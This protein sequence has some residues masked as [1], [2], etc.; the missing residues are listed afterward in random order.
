MAEKGLAL[1][2]SLG[3]SGILH[4]NSSNLHACLLNSPWPVWGQINDYENT[5]V[6]SQAFKI[7]KTYGVRRWAALLRRWWLERQ[8]I[9]K[10][11]L[12]LCNSQFTQQNIL[13]A[14]QPKHPERLKILYKA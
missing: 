10:Q 8:F 7:I 6:F 9:N 11:E 5:T 3:P 14:Y 4:V 13:E 2:R 1:A 12:T